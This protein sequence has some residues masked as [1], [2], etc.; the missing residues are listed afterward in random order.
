MFQPR[1]RSKT[2]A[3]HNRLNPIPSQRESPT[4]PH[5]R[6]T[7]S[8]PADPLHTPMKTIHL[9][10]FLASPTLLWAAAPDLSKVKSRSD[11]DVAIASTTDPSTKKALSD[12]AL[13]ILEAATQHPHVESIIRTVETA[14]GSFTKINTTPEPLKH[15]AGQEL[16]IFDT[17]TS[18]NTSIAK[19]KAHA[20]RG[21]GEDPYDTAF[22]E[23]LGHVRSLE[24]VK[25]VAT[26]IEDSWLPPLFNLKALQSLSIEGTARGLPGN[27]A[28]GDASLA[29]FRSLSE[30]PKLNS[31]E[32]AYFGQAT[33]DGLAMLSGLKNLE[34]FTFRGSPVNGH[35]FAKFKGWTNLKSI[36]FHSNN[37]DDE[38]FGYVCEN[39][40]NLEFIKLWHSKL[41]TDASADHLRK[42]KHLKGIEISCSKATS[43]LLK[44]LHEL[45][46]EY[47]AIEY[48]VI[49]PAT[50]ALANIKAV[51]TLRRLSV[52]AEKFSDADLKSLATITQIEELS[53]SGLDLT[54]E[55]I[56]Q[57][58]SLASLKSLTLIRYGKGYPDE[59]QAKVKALLP[60]V[61]LNFVK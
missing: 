5:H 56:P 55:R 4:Q 38:G 9:L 61:A 15:A 14:P 43:A 54:D 48:G 24:S 16:P 51:T 10:L 33:D 57:L 20:Y 13:A 25:I 6:T 41:I 47:A 28:L 31:L 22:L 52:S 58:R 45:P 40:P 44:H 37:L 53:L 2:R 8:L 60:K 39:F 50:D 19:G 59:T 42:L 30:C 26:K 36:N 3:D 23:H 46:L 32:F 29:R 18:V 7:A 1:T 21:A 49:S 34:K 17:L 35:A 27:P 12:H 11:L